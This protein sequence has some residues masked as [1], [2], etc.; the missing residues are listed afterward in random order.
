M[1]PEAL[2][3]IPN[4]ILTKKEKTKTDKLGRTLRVYWKQQQA[5]KLSE[6]EP[7]KDMEK[8]MRDVRAVIIHVRGC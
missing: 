1:L 7:L 2:G 5:Q 3:S 6:E 8:T 4:A